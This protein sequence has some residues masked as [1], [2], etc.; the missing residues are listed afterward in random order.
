MEALPDRVETE[1]L[2]LRR[3]LAADVP[4]LGAAIAASL[5]HLRPWMP[6][7]AGEPVPP[8]DRV[9][10]IE[11]GERAWEAGGD[12]VLGML[13]ADG[14]VVGGT[15][16]HRRV[17]PDALEI[18]YWVH[19]DHLGRGYATEAARALTTVAFTVPGV[20]RVEIHHDRANAPSRRIPEKLGYRSLGETPDRIT[21]PGE[22]GVDCGWEMTSADWPERPTRRGRRGLAVR[23][24]R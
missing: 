10:W 21:A 15:G 23:R 18:G 8:A 17:G 12:L 5:D 19:V 2:V 11:E 1:R 6:W 20:E 7:A 22:V 14:T 3:W 24:T 4:A 9:R 13:L 16:F